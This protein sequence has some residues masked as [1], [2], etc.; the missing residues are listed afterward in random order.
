MEITAMLG[1]P[2]SDFMFKFVSI[3]LNSSTNLYALTPSIRSAADLLYNR[4]RTTNRTNGVGALKSITAIE[5][6]ICAVADA[7]EEGAGSRR[8]GRGG[9]GSCS[10][11]GGGVG[12]VGGG[13][14]AVCV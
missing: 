10:L 7:S 9:G 14:V 12:G 13:D 2:M 6:S 11:V 4:S 5:L 8:L 1:L 3:F